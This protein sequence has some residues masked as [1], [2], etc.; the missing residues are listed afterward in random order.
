M[1]RQ[2]LPDGMIPLIKI[3][4]RHLVAACAMAGSSGPRRV[5]E[6][7]GYS[8]GTISRWQSD[9]HKDLMPTEVVFL[10]EFTIQRP[11]FA[12]TLAELTGHRLTPVAEDERRL[13][14]DV[15]AL[16]GDL[17][18]IVGSGSRVGATLGAVL[19]DGRVTRREA[20]EALADIA[21][22][23]DSLLPAERRLAVLAEEPEGE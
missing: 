20:R 21:R 6:L 4:T 22:H 8:A 23:K 14:D 10:L 13:G 7:T 12:R 17:I 1:D 19:E 11:V 2:L 5:E 16:T 3:A 18:R 15:A 9:A